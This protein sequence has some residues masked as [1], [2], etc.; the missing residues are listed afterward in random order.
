V[1]GAVGDVDGQPRRRRWPHHAV[2]RAGRAED[3]EGVDGQI[4]GAP[5]LLNTLLEEAR[6]ATFPPVNYLI[7]T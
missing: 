4:V 5:T 2:H 1:A 3:E 6:A 7:K